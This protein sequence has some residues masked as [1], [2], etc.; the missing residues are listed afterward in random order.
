MSTRCMIFV[1]VATEDNRKPVI[2][3]P[4]E[5]TAGTGFEDKENLRKWSKKNNIIAN[6]N[7]LSIYCHFDGYPKGVGANLQSFYNDYKKAF[8]LM[9]AG[10]VSDIDT[11]STSFMDT[12]PT[13]SKEILIKDT[14]SI[15][16]VYLFHNGEWKFLKTGSK[17][18][19]TV[20]KPEDFTPLKD[21]LT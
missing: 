9:G 10:A 16:Y 13:V 3:N 7:Y 2:Y 6:G 5:H 19:P 12:P 14:I 15:E 11:I 20:Y 18:N 4:A 1:A 21:Y 17:N 8:N